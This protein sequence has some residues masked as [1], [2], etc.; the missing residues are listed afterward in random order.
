MSL[1]FA[2]LTVLL[3]AST[4]LAEEVSSVPAKSIAVKKEIL[5]KMTSK[6][7]RRPSPGIGCPNLRV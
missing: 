1:R 6:T 3:F 4:A 5:F 7:Q 2:S